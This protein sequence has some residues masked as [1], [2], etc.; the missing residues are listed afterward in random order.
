ML[1]VGQ[2]SVQ[3][4]PKVSQITTSPSN[5]TPG[6]VKSAPQCLCLVWADERSGVLAPLGKAIQLLP[7]F[8]C[9]IQYFVYNMIII[10]S[11]SSATS[12]S[13]S[14]LLC[15]FWFRSIPVPVHPWLSTPVLSAQGECQVGGGVW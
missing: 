2:H 4:D 15:Q 5:V 8:G 14:T 9:L 10:I 6:S 11:P 3:V 12:A 1:S 13:V 7:C